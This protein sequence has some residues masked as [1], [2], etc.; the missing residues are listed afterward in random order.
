ML[1]GREVTADVLLIRTRAFARYCGYS[2][3]AQG[4]H[5]QRESRPLGW[6]SSPEA[7]CQQNGHLTGRWPARAAERRKRRP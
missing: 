2:A 3:R 5:G 4:G 7:P 1:A 6:P